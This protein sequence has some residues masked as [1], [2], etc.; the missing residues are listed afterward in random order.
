MV[1]LVLHIGS[2]IGDREVNLSRCITLLDIHLGN[3][4]KSSQ[5]YATEA[6]GYKDQPEFLNQALL[7]STTKSPTEVLAITKKIEC[8]IG[9]EKE[10]FWGPR[11]IDIDIIFYGDLVLDESYL[12]I[13]H[14]RM[15]NRK[16]VLAPVVDIIPEYIHPVHGVSMKKMLELC[17]DASYVYP[18]IEKQII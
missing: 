1:N 14:P 18:S 2:N 17:D 7:F 9:K 13:P 8:V 6:W 11:R 16:F 4:I 12:A 10:F 5:I 3:L 15:T